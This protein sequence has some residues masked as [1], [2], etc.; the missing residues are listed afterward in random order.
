M[1]QFIQ[2]INTEIEKIF[3]KVFTLKTENLFEIQTNKIVNIIAPDVVT[4]THGKMSPEGKTTILNRLR[5]MKD[6]DW[7]NNKTWQ[8]ILNSVSEVGNI[9]PYPVRRLE[10]YEN[11]YMKAAVAPYPIEL[12]D[13]DQ[14]NHLMRYHICIAKV[15]YILKM[16]RRR[17]PT[18]TIKWVDVGCGTGVI[19]NNVNVPDENFKLI[20]LDVKDTASLDM[21]NSNKLVEYHTIKPFDT[22]HIDEESPHLVTFFETIEHIFDPLEFLEKYTSSKPD[23]VIAGSPLE[24]TIPITPNKEHVWGFTGKGF[25]Y[26]FEQ[27]GMRTISHNMEYIGR[28][29]NR[30]AHDWQTIISADEKNTTSSYT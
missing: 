12:K 11:S 1:N 5:H 30:R 23:Y 18:S 16:L 9:I 2:N 21:N 25:K 20:G 14:L 15:E 10:W 24:E 8:Y 17:Y 27:A 3:G 19:L 29:A 13:I 6:W 4:S 28:Y 22:V 26:L 7:Q